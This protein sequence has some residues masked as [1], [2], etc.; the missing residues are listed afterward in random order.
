[1]VSLPPSFLW[2]EVHLAVLTLIRDVHFGFP[3][4]DSLRLKQETNLK[5][6]TFQQ[7]CVF[8]LSC[9]SRMSAYR[10]LFC[11]YGEAFSFDDINYSDEGIYPG[12]L[13]RHRRL[14]S[15]EKPY[16]C[17]YPDCLAAFAYSHDVTR[18][19]R[20]HT[21]EKPYKC[22]YLGCHVSF[23]YSCDLIKHKRLHTGEKPYKCSHPGCQSAFSCASNLNVHKRTHTG[24]KPYKCKYQDC[25][26]SFTQ[27]SHL[28]RHEKT[29]C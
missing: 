17:D 25:H 19:K 7:I 4:T 9:F 18:H 28:K 20:V 6:K 1:L 5:S 23:A 11:P 21:K 24:E 15:G 29:H 13:K 14:H 2:H 22:N 27:S 26:A 12:D 16:R 3:F 8:L 10:A